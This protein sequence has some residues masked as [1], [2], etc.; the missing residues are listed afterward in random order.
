M[1]TFRQ[2]CG[3]LPFRYDHDAIRVLLVTSRESR[4]WVIPKGWPMKGK[5]AHQS[6]AREAFE[7]AGLKGEIAHDPLGH[8][9]YG[10]RLRDGAV[11]PVR[12]D[13]FPLYVLEQRRRWPE[14]EQRE[15]AWF[16][17]EEAAA[18]V[19]EQE[20]AELILGLGLAVERGRK[21]KKAA[22]H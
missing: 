10:K 17:P 8:Y 9:D 12:V 5:S 16:T 21:V 14:Y 6:A 4:R 13:V 18:A 2:Q 15:T 11:V 20:L 1:T 7:E 19:E 3:A 22:S